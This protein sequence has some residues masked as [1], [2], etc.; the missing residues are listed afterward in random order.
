MPNRNEDLV[1]H[2]SLEVSLWFE[3]S[4]L[5]RTLLLGTQGMRAAGETFLFK[6]TLETTDSYKTRLKSSTLLNIFSK[7][8]SFLSGQ[9]FQRDVTFSEETNESFIDWSKSIDSAG[10]KLDVFAKRSFYT[11]IGKGA[12]H[13]LIDLPPKNPD[14]LTKADQDAAGIRPYFKNIRPEDVLGCIIDEDGFLIQVRIQ[15]TVTK[16]VGDFS[17]IT[18]GRVRVLEPGYWRIYEETDKGEYTLI[19]EGEFSIPII[20]FVSF[21]PGEED[22]IIS[23]QTPMIDL[24]E[25]NAKHWRTS[26]SQDNYLQYCRFPLYFGRKL[27]DLEVLPMG[28]SMINSDDDNAD[29]KTVEMTGASIQAGAFDIKETEAQM[30]LYGL[31]QLVPRSGNMTATEKMITSAESNSSLGTWAIEFEGFLQAA[32]EIAGIFMG[33]EFPE[34]G[35]QVNKEYNFGIAEPEELGRI[36]ESYDKGILSAQACFG[37]FRRRGVF[38]EHLK[39]EDMAADIEQEKRES[40]D[41]ARLAGT[42]FGDGGDNKKEDN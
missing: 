26:S 18:I 3:I 31:Q 10:N 25:L 22:S 8:S 42:A 28:R 27:G 36:L 16:R 4:R 14:V 2:V 15:E 30:A 17:T 37:E 40:I 41:F 13:I 23:G 32:F 12:S 11:G 34:Y 6:H 19:E 29:L 7:T 5:P 24:A 39:W 35:V 20:P 21:I 1:N 33:I 9:V 38:D